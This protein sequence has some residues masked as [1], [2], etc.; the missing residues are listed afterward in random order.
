MLP[1]AAG[2]ILD[3]AAGDGYVT[4]K[5]IEMGFQVVSADRSF[6][7]PHRLPRPVEIDLNGALPFPDGYFDGIVSVET[8]E[9]LENPWCFVR[10]LSRI[11]RTGGFIIITSPN[12]ENLQSRLRMLLQGELIWF[13]RGNIKP[14]GHITPIF[15]SL[16]EEMS[17]RAGLE[18]D[19]LRFSRA[20]LPRT[21]AHFA[22]HSALF[23]ECRLSRFRKA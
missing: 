1:R 4:R 10:E 19:M 18:R 17:R 5:M 8:I 11:T 7:E 6:D 22:V 21:H 20:R 15:A 14:L 23:G 3:A 2:L 16:L 13:G 9:H 12:V